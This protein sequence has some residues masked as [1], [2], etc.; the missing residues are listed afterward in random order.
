MTHLRRVSL[1]VAFALTMLLVTMPISQAQ[2]GPAQIPKPMQDLS[3]PA[4]VSVFFAQHPALT[5]AQAEETHASVRVTTDG[6]A[7]TNPKFARQVA[8]MNAGLQKYRSLQAR[9]SSAFGTV[10]A[11][12]GWCVYLP[13]WVFHAY[14]TYVVWA[15]GVWAT[16]GLFA[17][18]SVVGIP[19]GALLTAVGIWYGVWAWQ[20]DQIFQWRGYYTWGAVVCF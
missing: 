18:V 19:L 17:F 2:N 11:S 16:M 8:E 6:F 5:S 12:A 4:E 13:P 20:A 15:G 1:A 3:T 7:T 9:P 14:I 10:D